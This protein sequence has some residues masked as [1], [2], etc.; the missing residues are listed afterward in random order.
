MMI[1]TKDKRGDKIHS[2]KCNEVITY[3]MKKDEWFSHLDKGVGD[4]TQFVIAVL[5]ILLSKELSR[6]TL[7]ILLLKELNCFLL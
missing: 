1:K 2:R 6:A 4:N 5:I 7:I 3:G